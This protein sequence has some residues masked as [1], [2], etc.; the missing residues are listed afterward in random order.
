VFHF[1][2][3]LHFEFIARLG[4]LL[5]ALSAATLVTAS[6]RSTFSVSTVEELL[7]LQPLLANPADD[8]LQPVVVKIRPGMYLLKDSFRVGRSH[9]TLV[10]EQGAKL[11]LA[12]NVNEPV[13]VLGT[14]NENAGE[15]DVIT[16]I[17][18]VGLEID[19][20]KER[21]SSEFSA[22]RPWIRN[23]GIDVRAVTRLSVSNV[24]ANNN[25]SGG[26]VISW[27]CS[28]VRVTNST[29]AKNHYDGV[30]FYAS[31][32]V[33]VT[34]CTMK[35]NQ[36][37]GVSLD[38][39]FVD[40]RFSE[41]LIESNGDVGVFARWSAR[42]EFKDCTIRDS[43]NWAFFLAH[44]ETGHGVFDVTITGGEITRNRGGVCQG[45]VEKKQ[46]HGTRVVGAR[47]SANE[48]NGRLNLQTSGAMLE[49]IDVPGTEPAKVSP[50]GLATIPGPVP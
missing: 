46:S 42:L 9:V 36:A 14:Q 21:Q 41:C 37:A 44:N 39:D 19:G 34:G 13:L 43:G 29:F 12:N 26:L 33:E 16:D 47:F 45:S 40:S 31:T 7:A 24:V 8:E 6:D 50:V 17:A 49:S 15:A 22:R 1:V 4:L 48:R 32:R 23:N 27:G 20:N 25:R 5:S 38:N 30:A 35:Q 2:R 28:D 10:G 18:V 3:Y 11:V